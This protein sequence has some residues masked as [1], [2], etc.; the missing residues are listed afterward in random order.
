MD[1][2][3]VH[4]TAND[5]RNGNRD[6]TTLNR[7]PVEPEL[8]QEWARQDMVNQLKP[9]PELQLKPRKVIQVL[10]FALGREP[11]RGHE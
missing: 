8:S 10:S 9:V 1:R 11:R 4:S 6:R 2:P 5:E 7:V 3:V